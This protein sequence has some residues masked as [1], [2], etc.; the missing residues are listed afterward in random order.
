MKSE[1]LGGSWFD[2]APGY[3]KRPQALHNRG[4]GR[5]KGPAVGLV[6][7]VAMGAGVVVLGSSEGPVVTPVSSTT[8]STLAGY[9]EDPASRRP[10]VSWLAEPAGAIPQPPPPVPPCRAA[11]LRAENI[12]GQGA[13]GHAAD[14]VVISNA[15]PEACS[16]DDRVVVE[17]RDGRGRLVARS[18]QR[19]PFIC[20][21]CGDN[22]TPGPLLVPPLSARPQPVQDY[23]EGI[24]R[25]DLPGFTIAQGECPGGVFPEGATLFLVVPDGRVPIANGLPLPFDYRCDSGPEQTPLPG[26]PEVFAGFAMGIP[27]RDFVDNGKLAVEISAPATVRAGSR[28][29]YRIRTRVSSG[30]YL[31]VLGCPGFTERLAGVSEERHLL[32]CGAVEDFAERQVLVDQWFD[33]VLRVPKGAPA[34]RHALIWELDPPFRTAKAST[35]VEVL[36]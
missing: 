4:V 24:K 25:I 7:I 26:R 33:M 19:G 29:R 34:G 16:I 30:V 18:G 12:G 6:L 23:G 17:L 27:V 2:E 15:T 21:G 3:P 8:S 20:S 32:N 22:R 9:P 31:A 28:L 35:V 11:Q 1:S 10:V 36:R 5:L 13:T 14:S